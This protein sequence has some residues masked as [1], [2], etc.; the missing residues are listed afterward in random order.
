[1]PTYPFICSACGHTVDQRLTFTQYDA[2]KATTMSV[3]CTQC[4]CSMDLGFQPGAVSFVLKEGPSGGWVT[5]AGKEKAYRA[6]R[7]QVMARREKDH[8]FKNHL[9]PNYNGQDTGSW[10]EAQAMARSE[11][12]EK[13][14]GTYNDLVAHEGSR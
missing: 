2:V 11:K 7:N 12:G 6:K 9:Q 13:V 1:M 4:G 5:K 10:R 3:S 8:V 14:A